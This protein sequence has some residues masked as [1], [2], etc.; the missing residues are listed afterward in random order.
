MG[1]SLGKQ[2]QISIFGES[3][4]DYIG[5]TI[6]G[7]DSGILIDHEL[8][9]KDLQRRKPQQNFNTPRKE[10]DEYQIISGVFNGYTTGTPLT[11]LVKN[12]NRHSSDYHSNIPRASHAD[13]SGHIKYDGFQDYRGGGH[14]S[15]RLTTPLVIAGS[16]AKMILNRHNIKIQSHIYKVLNIFDDSLVT[17]HSKLDQGFPMLNEKQKNKVLSLL[18]KIRHDH[19]SVGGIIET[20]IFNLPAGIGEPFF[21]SLESMLSHALFSIPSVKGIS[22][23]LGENFSDKLGSEVLDEFYYDNDQVKTKTNFNGGING[24]ISNG[25][26]ITFKTTLKPIASIAKKQNTIDLET[27]TNTSYQ[28]NGRHDATIINRVIVIIEALS[29]ITLVDCC[30]IRWGYTWQ[31]H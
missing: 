14:F 5:V 18:E 1:N 6:S 12:S 22:F 9:K 27:K 29:A 31:N 30:S 24:G 4:Q 16:I 10:D 13:Y 20:A 11:I 3:H 21:D 7:I 23:G 19:D 8:I 26:P 25:M 15:G 17:Y 2:F 28:V